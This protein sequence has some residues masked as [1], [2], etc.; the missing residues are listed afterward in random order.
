MPTNV[1]GTTRGGGERLQAS[2]S[3]LE[4]EVDKK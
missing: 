4:A 1:A 2:V 3:N